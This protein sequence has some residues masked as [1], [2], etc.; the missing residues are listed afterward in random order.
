MGIWALEALI[1]STET[2]EHF[3]L[4]YFRY[5]FKNHMKNNG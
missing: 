2:E 1:T 5:A 3:S 4:R